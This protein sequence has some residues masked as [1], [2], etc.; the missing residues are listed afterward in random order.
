MGPPSDL[1]G[2]VGSGYEAA[3]EDLSFNAQIRTELDF[4]TA[5]IWA[6]A[7]AKAIHAIV[8]DREYRATNGIERIPLDHRLFLAPTHV[9][10]FI[11]VVELVDE[12]LPVSAAILGTKIADS[13][14]RE[15]EPT[16]LHIASPPGRGPLP[17]GTEVPHLARALVDAHLRRGYSALVAAMALALEEKP[18]ADLASYWAS[19][20]A[21]QITAEHRHRSVISALSQ[22]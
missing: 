14:R 7:P 21:H 9:A 15:L 8:G 16:L 3:D 19:L 17:G 12:D 10:V 1:A 20:T 2:P 11:M 22:L 5:L 4:L 18:T 13:T 6:P